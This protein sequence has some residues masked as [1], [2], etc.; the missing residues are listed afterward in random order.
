[1]VAIVAVACLGLGRLGA[2]LA[3]QAR[4]D[5]AADAAALAAADQLALGHGARAAQRAAADTAQRNGAELVRCACAGRS[6]EVEVVIDSSGALSKT[7]RSRA[8]AEVDL[9][10]AA[11]RAA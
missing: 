7:A 5:L 1:M 8:R 10:P 6:A 4:A 2:P 3:R 9:S 11:R